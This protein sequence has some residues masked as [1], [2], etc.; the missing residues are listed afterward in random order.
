[1]RNTVRE[2][3]Y[4]LNIPNALHF[5]Q[6][7]TGRCLINRFI[8]RFITWTSYWP[9]LLQR[10]EKH[11]LRTVTRLGATKY[12]ALDVSIRLR[13]YDNFILSYSIQDSPRHI[14]NVLQGAIQNFRFQLQA[15]CTHELYFRRFTDFRLKCLILRYFG[16]TYYILLQ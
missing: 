7:Q 6:S 3:Q 9:A 11:A 1:V 2:S 5:V 4:I 16:L 8:T 10:K 15:S 13:M 14:Y 12:P